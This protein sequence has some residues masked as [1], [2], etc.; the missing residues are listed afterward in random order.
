MLHLYMSKY[1]QNPPR[2]MNSIE[3]EQK[4]RRLR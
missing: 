4:K 1:V 2:V 3:S